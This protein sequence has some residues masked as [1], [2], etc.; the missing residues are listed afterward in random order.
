MGLQD[1]VRDIRTGKRAQG[2]GDHIQPCRGGWLVALFQS[3][4]PLVEDKVDH[5][6][7]QCPA[8]N[9]NYYSDG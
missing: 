1:V 4:Y 6:S 8:D 3:L 7:G 9:P 5:D 2:H